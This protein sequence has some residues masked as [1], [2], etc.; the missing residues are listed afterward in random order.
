M[1]FLLKR[2]HLEYGGEKFFLAL[3]VGIGMAFYPPFAFWFTHSFRGFP[4]MISFPWSFIQNV[5]IG[6]IVFL[7]MLRVF[8]RF[9]QEQIPF[10]NSFLK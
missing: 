2:V 8:S 6:A 1:S 9:R 3:A 7:V 5:F 10:S 4:P